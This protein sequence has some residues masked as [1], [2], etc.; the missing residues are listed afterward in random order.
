MKKPVLF[1]I[2]MLPFYCSL[3]HPM[4]KA[5]E[6]IKSNEAIVFETTLNTIVIYDHLLA[7][8]LA[9]VNKYSNSR[10]KTTADFCQKKLE[11]NFSD[12]Y[13]I[14]FAW[15]IHKRAYA[16]AYCLFY[17][18]ELIMNY[19]YLNKE[20]EMISMTA[21]WKNDPDL[22]LHKQNIFFNHKGDA[23]Y[24]ASGIMEVLGRGKKREIIEYSLSI[25]NEQKESRCV[26]GKT[27]KKK[28]FQAISLA[29][30]AKNSFLDLTQAI[31]HSSHQYELS[32]PWHK[33]RI[34]VFHWDGVAVPQRYRAAHVYLDSLLYLDSENKP[35]I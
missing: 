13:Q 17:R 11:A 15:H 20:D 6:K 7:C 26:L 19:N 14:N 22:L 18:K 24:Y 5:N 16:Y 30:I 8:S 3:L 25:D 4:D 10:I 34:K 23:C 28:E 12:K 1:I 31:L 29:S 27:N 21:E 35:I 2:A 33:D 32:T 9:L